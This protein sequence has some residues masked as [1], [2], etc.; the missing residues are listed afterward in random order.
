MTEKKAKIVRG[1]RT[2]FRKQV[3][4]SSKQYLLRQAK[5]PYVRAAQAQGYRSRAA[6]K[7]L[8]VQE[9]HHILRPGQIVVDLGAAPG[10][11]SQVAANIME[12][13]GKV[14]ALDVL[15]MPELAGVTFVKGDFTEEETLQKLK[16]YMREDG[17]DAD[18]GVHVVLSDMAPNTTGHAAS[19]HL[20]IM[21][22]A[23]LAADFALNHLKLKGSFLCKLFQ[24]GEEVAF[25]DQLRKHF[26]VVKFV[27]PSSS[28][29]DSREMFLLA[30]G[31]KG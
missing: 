1:G 28:R 7:L 8:E 9:K 31:F 2:K 16:D 5:D 13:K 19:D 30:T 15:L 17:Y 23:E 24:G 6:F 12:H 20:Q 11:W 25:R 27:K 29:K 26:E 18:K 22:L 21:G 3:S 4:E 14:F 10:G